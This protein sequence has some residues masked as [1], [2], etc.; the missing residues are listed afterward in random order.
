MEQKELK[1]K[2]T[3]VY[4]KGELLVTT[5]APNKGKKGGESVIDRAHMSMK[6]AEHAVWVKV[7]EPL[8]GK[9]TGRSIQELKDMFDRIEAGVNKI[10]A[11]IEAGKPIKEVVIKDNEEPE[12]IVDEFAF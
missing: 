10:V 11:G 6:G 1:G 12:E 9:S 5:F 7:L 3:F 2:V 4:H 8:A